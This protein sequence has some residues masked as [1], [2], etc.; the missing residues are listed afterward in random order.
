MF[1]CAT[2]GK[3]EEEHG[4]GLVDLPV[5]AVNVFV[6]A[7]PQFHSVQGHRAHQVHP[8]P[9]VAVHP[10]PAIA[11]PPAG[12]GPRDAR[13]VSTNGRG[14]VLHQQARVH[15]DQDAGGEV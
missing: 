8:L 9:Q 11:T 4:L 2:E 15:G 3:E 13:A 5:R 6:H 12:D 1:D 7:Q 14:E 10:R